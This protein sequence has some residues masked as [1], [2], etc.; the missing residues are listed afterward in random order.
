MYLS[1]VRLFC[2]SKH[3]GERKNKKVRGMRGQRK[4]GREVEEELVPSGGIPK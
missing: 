1:W 4:G 2:A 3:P